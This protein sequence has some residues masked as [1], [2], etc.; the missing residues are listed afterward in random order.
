[1]KKMITLRLNI[2]DENDWYIYETIVMRQIPHTEEWEGDTEEDFVHIMTIS[3]EDY[4]FWFCEEEE[5]EE[6]EG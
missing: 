5:E 1:M 2:S 6:E 3:E 4:K